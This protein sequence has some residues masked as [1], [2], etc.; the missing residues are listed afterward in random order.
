MAACLA[1]PTA[2]FSQAHAS[3]NRAI[4][5]CHVI[6]ANFD[7][8]INE[9]HHMVLAAS[10][11]NNENYTFRQMLQ[12]EDSAEFIKA[13]VDETRAHEQRGHWEVV[14]RS[15]LPAGTKVIQ[16]IW[17]FK[18]K[19]FPDGTLN[20]YKARLCAHGGMQEW[21]VNYWETY[22]PVV[23][24]ISVRFLLI[25]GEI[26]GL[27]S[28]TIDFVLAFPQA[29]LD[30]PV[31]M[32]FPLGMEVPGNHSNGR[33]LLRLRKSL[34][35]LKQASANWHEML[36]NGLVSSSRELLILMRQMR[37]TISRVHRKVRHSKILNHLLMQLQS[38]RA[39]TPT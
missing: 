20:K 7:G 15:S 22:A 1:Q 33:P 21:G 39:Q 5:H 24:W 23:N 32:D 14:P 17:S 26:A 37:L 35:G 4:H 10:K 6:N 18:R 19:R 30:V 36:K 29:D 27:E 2:A 31:Y 9:V 13:M 38:S 8:S 11:S 12:Q 25:L 28:R 34:Y 16:A 3:V